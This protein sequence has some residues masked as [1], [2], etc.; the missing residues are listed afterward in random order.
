MIGDHRPLYDFG[1]EKYDVLDH[2]YKPSTEKPVELRTPE[3]LKLIEE[4]NTI[5]TFKVYVISKKG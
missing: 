3:D 2:Y 1:V 5:N 4:L